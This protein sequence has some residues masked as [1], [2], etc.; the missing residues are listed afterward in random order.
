MLQLDFKMRYIAIIAFSTV[1]LLA[2]VDAFSAPTIKVNDKLP[3]IDLHYG[4]PPDNVNIAMYGANK[5]MIIVGLPGAFTPTCSSIQIPGYLRNTEA[6][7][8]AGIDVVVICAVNDGAV[9]TSWAINQ[10]IQDSLL[11]FLAD[12]FGEFTKSLGMEL[13]HPG[14]ISK[15]LVGR[16]KRF[17]LYVENCVIKHVAVS[18]SEDDP[19]GDA[20]PSESC[21]DAMLDA[22]NKIS[23]SK[24][25][26][27]AERKYT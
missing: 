8:K 24:R 20:N 1:A 12:P 25:L 6:L 17:A 16:C 11:V 13:T 5:K 26:V 18:E 19:A 27:V 23:L 9:M 2:F 10:G 21:C 22:I 14:P 7:R 3:F 15:G 4:F